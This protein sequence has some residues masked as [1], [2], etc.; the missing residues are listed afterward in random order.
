MDF[1][2]PVRWLTTAPTGGRTSEHSLADEDPPLIHSVRDTL[3]AVRREFREWYAPTPDELK[4]LW[5][6]G[7]FVV[8][9]NVLLGLYQYPPATLDE[10]LK[11]LERVRDR[12]WLP[13]QAGA[14]FHR[15]R[16]NSLPQ[17]RAVLERLIKTIE[18]LAGHLDSLGLP[19]YHPVLD[20]NSVDTARSAVRESFESLLQNV[21]GALHLTSEF[22]AGTVLGGDPVRDR[23]TLLFEGK[24][25]SAL[26]PD[27]L[28]RIYKEGAVRYERER[29]PGYK[30]RAKEEP[31]RYA[32]L[33]IWKEILKSGS[34][35]DAG[36]RGVIFITNDRK[37]DWWLRKKEQMLGPRPELVREYLDEVGEDFHMYTPADFLRAAPQFLTEVAVSEAAISDVGRISVSSPVAAILRT[38]R[39]VLPDAGTRTRALAF[40]FDQ[41]AGGRIQRAS[42]I[43]AAIERFGEFLVSNYISTPLFFSLVSHTYGQVRVDADVSVRLR[44]RA[45]H[46]ADPD[47]DKEMFV[48]RAHAAWLAQALYRVRFEGFTDEDLLVAFFGDD[49]SDDA[50]PLL[51]QARALVQTDLAYARG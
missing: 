9:A 40:I 25:G 12:V 49:Y 13:Y 11:V 21:R 30:D 35:R 7:T 3:P 5:Q 6:S 27:E 45:V 33:V 4:S 37:E 28:G 1:G 16:E 29:P 8:D 38:Q 18:E 17:Q 34:G 48:R 31:D 46:V 51:S 39:M 14:E 19:E 15:N 2:L 10:F 44:D 41:L 43:N 42:D 36:R 32:D 26:P 50:A 20:L 47:L 22:P 24:V 23:L